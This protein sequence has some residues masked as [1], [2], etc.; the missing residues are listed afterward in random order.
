MNVL[1]TQ[2][3]MRVVMKIAGLPDADGT[4]FTEEALRELA[5]RDPRFFLPK[6]PEG[7]LQLEVLIHQGGST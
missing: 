4:V 7:R 3:P 1:P 2:D 5:T 6:G